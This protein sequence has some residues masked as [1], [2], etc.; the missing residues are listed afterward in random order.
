ME[1]DQ[2][3]YFLKIAQAQSFTRAGAELGIT[4]PA[5]SRS[6]GKLEAELG[7]PVFERQTRSVAL[8]DAGRTLQE[9][10]RQIVS[11]V[12]DTVAELADS[13]GA[14][15]IR[16]GA[17]PTVAPYFL[18]DLLR[19]F[20]EAHPA[21][22]A[23]VLEETTDRLLQRC[24]EG[25]VDVAFLAAPITAK[26]LDVEPLFEE[27]LLAV[28]ASTHP[29]T[30]KKSVSLLELREYPFVL[31]DETHCLS[32]AIVSF[33]RQ[34]SFQPVTVERTCQLAMVEELVSLGHGVSLIP[35]MAR[36]VDGSNRRTYRPVTRP[37]P[38][39]TIIMASNP[40]RYQ[41]RRIV[42]FKEFVRS[43]TSLCRHP[44]SDTEAAPAS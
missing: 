13:A 28:F 22:Q 41:S 1:L 42:R 23:I 15:R 21:I 33:C 10:A 35:R 8:T 27:E 7:Q 40:Y 36:M 26:Y 39:R 43:F 5:L 20:Q 31:L 14:G 38:T 9:R 17:I 6:I 2:L 25:E 29:L 3:R 18:P 24:S 4:Q 19:R 34:R 12:D 44:K 16:I 37:K 32:E 30:K 11:L